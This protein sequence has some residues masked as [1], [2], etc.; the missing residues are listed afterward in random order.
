MKILHLTIAVI[1]LVSTTLASP[2]YAVL[3]SNFEKLIQQCK[4]EEGGSDSDAEIVFVDGL[5]ETQ[6][7][8]CMFACIHEKLKIV[9]NIFLIYFN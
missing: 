2:D 1:F 5:P 9:K 4:S 6:E 3:Q 8:Q 7:G